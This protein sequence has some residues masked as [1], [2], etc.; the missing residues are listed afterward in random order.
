MPLNHVTHV[1]Q[2]SGLSWF[3]KA[4]IFDLESGFHFW[5]GHLHFSISQDVLSI[6]ISRLTVFCVYV[7]LDGRHGDLLLLLKELLLDAGNVNWSAA[8][9]MVCPCWK[10]FLRSS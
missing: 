10:H 1:W 9:H 8:A 4:S 6:I 7:A 5:C 2:L 3:G